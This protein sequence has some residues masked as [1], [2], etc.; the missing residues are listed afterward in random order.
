[1]RA[2]KHFASLLMV[3]VVIAATQSN[4]PH[5]HGWSSEATTVAT[6]DPG[7][8]DNGADS[9]VV[10]NDEPDQIAAAAQRRAHATYYSYTVV[11]WAADNTFCFATRFTRD[12]SAADGASTPQFLDA[13]ATANGATHIPACPTNPDAALPSQYRVALSFWRQEN[14]PHP[15]LTSR[16]DYAITGRPTYLEIGGPPS[17]DVDIAD[18][19]SGQV[20]HVHATSVYTVN[21]G[22]RWADPSD[23]RSASTTV[24]TS[25][26]GPYP[27]GDVIHTYRHVDGH[28]M[29]AVRQ[30]WTANWSAG[31]GLGGPLIGLHTDAELPFHVE[32][33]QAI[34]SG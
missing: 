8:F 10:A 18:P 24:T 25:Q 5:A 31:P 4:M 11:S 29:I 6:K 27:D 1:M 7:V 3:L 2:L 9:F 12:A 22:D 21:W 28:L 32:Q 34:V 17:L 19:V 26:G 33:V 23:A 30:E 14:L 13:V 16:P 20:V 15:S